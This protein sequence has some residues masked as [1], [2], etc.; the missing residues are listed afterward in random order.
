[1]ENEIKSEKT[2][3]ELWN[4]YFEAKKAEIDARGEWLRADY[5][6]LIGRNFAYASVAY[7]AWISAQLKAIKAERIYHNKLL[8]KSLESEEK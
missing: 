1:M 6:A 5:D 2:V 4:E 3:T 8:G 7:D